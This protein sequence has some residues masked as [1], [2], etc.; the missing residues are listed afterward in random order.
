MKIETARFEFSAGTLAQIP[1]G[2]LREIQ[3]WKID[4]DQ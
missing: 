2:D 3:C 4:V 1:P